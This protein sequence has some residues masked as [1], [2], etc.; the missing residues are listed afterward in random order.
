[1]IRNLSFFYCGEAISGFMRKFT[2][3]YMWTHCRSEMFMSHQS[4]NSMSSV[5]GFWVDDFDLHPVSDEEAL[6]QLVC[7]SASNSAESSEAA[8]WKMHFMCTVADGCSVVARFF[9]SVAFFLVF[10]VFFRHFPHFFNFT[11]FLVAQVA[12]TLQLVSSLA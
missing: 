12:C 2:H 5:V 3:Q 8:C 6:L 11:Q 1:M 4:N 10:E 7:G 9:V